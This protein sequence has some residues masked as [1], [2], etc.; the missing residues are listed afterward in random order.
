[1][2]DAL[3]KLLADLPQHLGRS[4]DVVVVED[5]VRIQARRGPPDARRCRVVALAGA[6]ALLLHAVQVLVPVE[7]RVLV[8]VG[9]RR[10]R[11][12][13]DVPPHLGLDGVK[14]LVV[15]ELVELLEVDLVVDVQRAAAGLPHKLHVLVVVRAQLGEAVE[16]LGTGGELVEPALPRPRGHHLVHLL[17][18][19]LLGVRLVRFSVV[20]HDA[21]QRRLVRHDKVGLLRGLL[22]ADEREEVRHPLH[23]L[24]AVGLHL[25]RLVRVVALVGEGPP[26]LGEEEGVL[27]VVQGVGVDVPREEVVDATLVELHHAVDQRLV[28]VDAV[29]ELEPRLHGLAALLLNLIHVGTGLEVGAGG[30]VVLLEHRDHLVHHLLLGRVPGQRPRCLELGDA[31]EVGL[32]PLAAGKLVEVVAGVDLGV[33]GALDVVRKARNLHLRRQLRRLLGQAFVPLV[34][35]HEPHALEALQELAALLA[36]GLGTQVLRVKVSIRLDE[37]GAVGDGEG[38]GENRHD[39][40]KGD[41]Y[42][43]HGAGNPSHTTASAAGGRYGPRQRA[44]PAASSG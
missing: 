29:D 21:R 10:C 19:A 16:G 14:G 27:L 4:R 41:K 26:A 39:R 2:G 24:G 32:V 23:K 44:V 20:L 3:P 40:G 17:P 11:V 25:R 8:H 6:R 33:D 18:R 22:A 37:R 43:R 36:L 30:P 7:E 1:M 42:D 34:V 31:V 5:L 35:H 15:D 28:V 13:D 12:L 9:E 38:D